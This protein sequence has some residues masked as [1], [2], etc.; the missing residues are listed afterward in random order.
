MALRGELSESLKTA[1]KAKQERE[2]ATLR[3]VLAGLKDRDIDA[4][5]KGKTDGIGDDE[6]LQMMQNMIRQRRDSIELYRKGGRQELVDQESAEI[7]I[8]E[9]FLPKQM[10]DA[11]VEA[12]AKAAIAEAGA[13]SIKDMGKVMAALKQRY[14][15]QMDFAKAGAAVKKLLG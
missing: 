11:A 13:A 1:M 2:V 14:A 5:T 15:G 12:A 7:A 4:R 9:R 8:I 6:I 10:D 3:M